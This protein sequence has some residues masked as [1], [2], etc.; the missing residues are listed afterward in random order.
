MMLI[1]HWATFGGKMGEATT[2]APNGL[3]P[4]DLTNNKVDP[5]DGPIGP[6]AIS[7]IMFLKF[8]GGKPPPLNK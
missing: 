4:P 1:F 7:K 3:R 5:L 2:C 8:S 6:T